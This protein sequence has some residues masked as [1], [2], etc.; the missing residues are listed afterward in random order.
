[1]EKQRS[2]RN[3]DADVDLESIVYEM[4]KKTIQRPASVQRPEKKKCPA[5]VQQKKK[6]KKE[7]DTKTDDTDEPKEPKTERERGRVFIQGPSD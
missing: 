4:C 7:V 1:M 2:I 6:K 3:Q 5:S